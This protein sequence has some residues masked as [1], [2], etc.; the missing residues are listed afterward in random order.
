MSGLNGKARGRVLMAGKVIFN[1]G[2]STIDCLVRR[3]TDEGATI[4]LES[5]FGIPEHFQLFITSERALMP[6]KMVWQSDKQVGVAFETSEPPTRLPPRERQQLVT[7]TTYFVIKHS[8]SARRST[9]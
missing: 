9:S 3:I 8:R 1:F 5:G 4:E 6:C 2:Q 7:P